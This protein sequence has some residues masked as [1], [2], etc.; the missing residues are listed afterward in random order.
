MFNLNEIWAYPTDTSFGLGVRADD[1]LGLERLQ[2]L[3]G[4]SK[5]KYFSLMVR[6]FEML[7]NFVIIPQNHNL[8][9]NFFFEKPRTVILQPTKKLP[10]T[11]FWPEKKIAF[12]I[13]TISEIAQKINFPIT[14]TSANISGD[15]PIFDIKKIKKIFGNQVMIYDKI[16][17]LPKISPSEI[18]DFTEK[19][20]TQLR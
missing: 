3:K 4:R 20:I 2:K 9:E 18:W 16:K 7:K 15:A 6:D 11:K 12:R 8:T 1:F 19:K 17:K 10:K 13:C 5:E 14:A